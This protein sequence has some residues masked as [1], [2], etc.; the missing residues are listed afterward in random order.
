MKYLALIATLCAGPTLAHEM[1][2]TYPEFKSSYVEGISVAKLSI[3][4]RRI[5]VDYYQ[6]D[7]Y[8]D[9]WNRLPF[10][11]KS[12][13]LRVNYLRIVDFE[14]YVKDEMVDRVGYICTISKIPVAKMDRTAVA[15]RICSKIKKD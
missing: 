4:N 13:L 11:A 8:D 7:V 9:K 2:P 1:T 12:R 3:F 15:S 6:V 10:A 5:D 14:V